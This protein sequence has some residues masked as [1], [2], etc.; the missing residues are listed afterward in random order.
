MSLAPL[1]PLPSIMVLIVTTMF[2]VSDAQLRAARPA[3]GLTAADNTPGAHL[4][5]PSTSH[6]R[7]VSHDTTKPVGAHPGS[8]SDTPLRPWPRHPARHPG[9]QEPETVV[10]VGNTPPGRAQL[11]SRHSNRPARPAHQNR[12]GRPGRPGRSGLQGRHSQ[13]ASTSGSPPPPTSTLALRGATKRAATPRR[14]ATPVAT[15]AEGC[16]TF[17]QSTAGSRPTKR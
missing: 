12:P 4:G 7:P 3:E 10:G 5:G 13:A 11:R 1:L 8:P 16:S 9:A 15:R 6:A 14:A 17:P 2:G